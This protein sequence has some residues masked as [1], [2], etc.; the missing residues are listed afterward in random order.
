MRPS[1]LWLRSL[2]A[3]IDAAVVFFCSWFI[4]WHWGKPAGPGETQLNEP[5]SILLMISIAAYW[6]VPEWL[7][8]AT[9][10]K[11]SCDLRVVTVGGKTISFSQAAKRNIL[12]LVDVF[13]WYLTGFIAAKLTPQR[14]RLGDLWAKTMVVSCVEIGSHRSPDASDIGAAAAS[15]A[16][17][18]RNPILSSR[19]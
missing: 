6:I 3:I 13:P 5:A 12:R 18:A 7:T 14:Q 1:G 4:V 16:G 15:G 2:A 9:F 19:K 10:G 17:E 8:G 11:W